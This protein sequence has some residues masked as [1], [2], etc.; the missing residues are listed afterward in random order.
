MINVLNKNEIDIIKNNLSIQMLYNKYQKGFNIFIEKYN[1]IFL[2]ILKFIKE[3]K[4]YES[5]KVVLHLILENRD[6]NICKVCG[7]QLKFSESRYRYSKKFCNN[8]NCNINKQKI[9]NEFR[10]L[11]TLKKYGVEHTSALQ[12]VIQKIKHTKQIKSLKQNKIDI[13]HNKKKKLSGYTFTFSKKALESKR[14]KQKKTCLKKYGKIN[15]LLLP[16]QIEQRKKEKYNFFYFIQIPKWKN[17]IIPMFSF[18][19]YHGHTHNQIYLWKCVKCGTI[20]SSR[21][22]KTHVC[23][24][25][26]YIPRCLKC[27]PYKGANGRTSIAETEIYKF[28]L[29]QFPDTIQNDKKLITPLELDIVIPSIKLAIEYNGLFWHSKTFKNE[30]Y[31]LNKTELCESKGY[32][33]I[34]IWEDQWQFNKNEIKQKLINIFNN[35]DINFLEIDKIDQLKLDRCWYSK[36]TK[37]NN[38]YLNNVE[39]PSLMCNN[40][41]NCGTLIFK[42]GNK[43]E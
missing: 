10:K 2:K 33:L 17:Y 34:H 28:C 29:G 19:E 32:R 40:C 13:K 24:E 37:I 9:I 31:H 25:F 18:E 26:Q 27:F 41:Y 7:K 43:N 20:F 8:P 23:D 16:E 39:K 38:F 22:W 21:I 4:E 35:N 3:H 1:E 5:V 42:K 11:N 12:S 30:N 6:L 15:N 36:N 14:Q